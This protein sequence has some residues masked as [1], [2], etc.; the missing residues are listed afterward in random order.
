LGISE[1]SGASQKRR[2]SG[3]SIPPKNLRESRQEALGKETVES[4]LK[5]EGTIRRRIVILLPAS[6]G[7][8]K[9][10]IGGRGGTKVWIQTFSANRGREHMN[11]DKGATI[12]KRIIKSWEGRT[13]GDV[14]HR[15]TLVDHL[16]QSHKKQRQRANSE[17]RGRTLLKT[18]ETSGKKKRGG[19]HYE[20]TGDCGESRVE[21]Q[22]R[23]R[24]TRPY[25]Q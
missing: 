17:V 25:M 8:K 13:E 21:Q 19:G 4:R 23:G 5:K 9:A 16:E 14:S 2:I 1:G 7:G 20:P 6:T 24:I 12:E 3:S 10:K 15:D 18:M 11:L 22:C